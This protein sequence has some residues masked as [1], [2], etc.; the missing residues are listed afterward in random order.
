MAEGNT[1][2]SAT[3]LAVQIAKLHRDGASQEDINRTIISLCAAG[4]MS[5]Q[6]A[7]L[8]WIEANDIWS[9]MSTAMGGLTPSIQTPSGTTTPMVM[10]ANPPL[11]SITP[12][13]E[14]VPPAWLA[15]LLSALPTMQKKSSRK[16][17]P[18]PE[19]FDGNRDK[20]PV[21]Y[22]QLTAKIE[23]DKEDFENN[24]MACDYAFGRLKGQ[25]ASLTLPYMTVNRK[26]QTWDFNEMLVFMKNMFGDPHAEERA[27]DKLMS[28]R[29]GNQNIRNY[30][31][32]FHKQLLLANT[33]MNENM[34][35]TIFRT[36]LSPRVQ[37]ELV[38]LKFKDL[39]ELQDRATQVADDLF[40]I[41]LHFYGRSSKGQ[42]KRKE[43]ERSGSDYQQ[44]LSLREGNEME[45]IEYTGYTRDQ[46]RSHYL[47]NEEYNHRRSERLCYKCGRPDHI[48]RECYW[49]RDQGRNKDKF[50]S[51][52]DSRDK[53]K[54]K[55]S[56]SVVTAKA[57]S[58]RKAKSKKTHYDSPPPEIEEEIS[59]EGL[60]SNEDSG[61]E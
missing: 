25:A 1:S 33:A 41:D 21:F 31:M 48:A 6:D 39:D 20:F 42:Y 15:T 47:S 32:E 18:D 4:G 10:P 22:Q 12:L 29:Q 13:P 7:E 51:K 28:I 11:A 59:S 57:S 45:G 52:S 37:K 27:Q 23:N 46:Y 35:M 14:S 40:R 34:K 16:R 9:A 8:R 17:L 44:S 61:K 54:K 2:L 60:S 43:V 3:T 56:E 58:S 30:V 26:N 55:K 36:G 50:K 38:G 53:L 5:E 24:K 49:N 19:M